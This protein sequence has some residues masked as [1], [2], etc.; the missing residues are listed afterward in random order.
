VLPEKRL[1][2]TVPVAEATFAP[3]NVAE[4]PT[5]FPAAIVVLV[6]VVAI[7]VGCLVTAFVR[8]RLRMPGSKAR[9][10]MRIERNSTFLRFM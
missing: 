10:R 8:F 6:S 1:Y 2:V 7:V 5:D 3:Y 4:S 9:V